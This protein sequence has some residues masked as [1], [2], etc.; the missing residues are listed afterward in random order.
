MRDIKWIY[1]DDDILVCH[2]P[3]GVATEGAKAYN[4]D[5]VSA[6]RNYLNRQN[7]GKT[8][9]RKP[10]YVATVH[11]LDQPVEGVLILAKNKKAATSLASQIKDRA[12]DKYYYALCRG[13]FEEKKG[14]LENLLVR[15]EDGFAAVVTE[16]ESK[17]L[18]DGAITSDNGEKI[19]IIAGEVKKAILE[20][21]VVVEKEDV[22]LLKVKLMTGRFHQIRVQMANLGHPIIG[23]QKYGSDESLELTQKMGAK[24]V[25]LVSFKY[26]IK[27]PSTHKRMEFEIT[28]DNPQIKEMLNTTT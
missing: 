6:A 23:D 11:R 4:M 27:H 19:R 12:T 7:R 20:Y 13:S 8:A 25:C 10:P 17:T 2:K 22:S 18:K 24:D 16:E 26:V 3:A 5:V 9:D 15:K 28:P 21:E 1:E 14:R